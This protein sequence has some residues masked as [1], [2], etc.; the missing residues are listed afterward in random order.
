M[1]IYQQMATNFCAWKNCIT[2]KNTEWEDKHYEKILD[3]VSKYMPRG[4]GFDNGTFFDFQKSNP[5]KLIFHTKFHHMNDNDCYDGWTE[6]AVTVT[7][8]LQF[9]YNIKV[10]GKDRNDIKE[11]INEVFGNCL[12]RELN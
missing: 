5:D 8:S 1:K 11:Y 6:H 12:D 3:I 4:S 7:P 2:S 9:G 10:T